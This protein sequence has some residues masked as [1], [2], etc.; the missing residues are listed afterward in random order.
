M[1]NEDKCNRQLGRITFQYDSEAKW[2][3]VCDGHGVWVQ[4][5]YGD[6]PGVFYSD[7]NT[8]VWGD[9]GSGLCDGDM[10]THDPE[11][12]AKGLSRG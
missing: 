10:I 12:C 4:G 11:W 5:K 7:S 3:S 1:A 2:H 6:L 8:L 9:G